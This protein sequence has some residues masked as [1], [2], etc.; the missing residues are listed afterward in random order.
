MND[1]KTLFDSFNA[2]NLTLRQVAQGFVNYKKFDDLITNKNSLLM[3]PRG[4]GK[5]TLLKMLTIEAL[6]EYNR[7]SQSTLI[8]DLPFISIYVP[9][10]VQWKMEVDLFKNEFHTKIEFI[11]LVPNVLVNTN[12]FIQTV[13]TFVALIDTIP[14][15]EVNANMKGFIED[16]KKIWKLPESTTASLYAI[17]Q[18][19]YKRL[20]TINVLINKAR[21]NRVDIDNYDYPD[22][23]YQEFLE[24]TRAACKAFEHF[25]D[26]SESKVIASKS[27]PFKWALCFDELELAPL[28]LQ[29]KLFKF[30]RSKDQDFIF[31]L[32]SIPI[33]EFIPDNHLP[34]SGSDYSPILLW[35]YTNKHEK[36][37]EEFCNNLIS[38]KLKLKFGTNINPEFLFG[39]SESE[40]YL[41]L[42]NPQYN[43]YSIEDLSNLKSIIVDQFF[44]LAQKDD[45]FAKFLVKKG[46][47]LKIPLSKDR[48][49]DSEIHR[50]IKP[51][52]YYRNFHLSKNDSVSGTRRRTRKIRSPF[53]YGWE[54]I[55][56]ISDGNPRLIIG[57]IDSILQN[58][59]NLNETTEIS[60]K[61]QADVLFNI[62]K[63]YLNIWAT[64]PNA[65]I[66]IASTTIT[67]KSFIQSIGNYF[68]ESILSDDFSP[69]PTGTFVVDDKINHK[70]V[71][72]IILGMHLGAFILLDPAENISPEGVINKKFR[73]SF[74][75]YP[76]FLLPI[77]KEEKP[78]ILSRILLNNQITI[79]QQSKLDL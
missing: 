51:I 32:T 11:D 37:W 30:F 9:T 27:K 17:E 16:L 61:T 28:W 29:T 12:I 44:Q 39:G 72:L 58:V 48:L 31:K 62:S 71:E 56:K 63:R 8:Y 76:Y 13:K 35:L 43:S 24:T 6:L 1:Y 67:L 5:T 22:Y 57:I 19:F 41:K 4:C 46:I 40:R 38:S 23:F 45:S 42:E 36:D 70:Y 75:L 15:K 78:N 34:S 69:S 59:N 74:V 79:V 77:R 66:E 33:L 10:D 55:C 25:F 52:A 54:N 47:D 73:L 53:S 60:I 64:H 49:E 21:N 3:G 2:R 7:I 20:D 65:N 68:Q 18:E 50:K 14:S 26:K